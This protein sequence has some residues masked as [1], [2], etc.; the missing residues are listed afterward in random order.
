[1][2]QRRGQIAWFERASR[3]DWW[4]YRTFQV[5]VIVLSGTTPVLVLFA[6]LPRPVQALPAAL[7]ALAS[8]VAASFH[9]HEDAVRWGATREQ[10]KSEL[11]QF[12]VRAG[13]YP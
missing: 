4:L 2:S 6:A 7:A 1:M 3:A 8:A 11:R 10:L 5:A 13:H 9:W 12:S